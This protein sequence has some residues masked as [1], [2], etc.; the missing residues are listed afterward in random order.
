MDIVVIRGREITILELMEALKRKRVREYIK[1]I[2]F[3]VNGKIVIRLKRELIS[4]LDSLPSLAY[5]LLSIEK[6]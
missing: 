1:G 5:D 3:K 6:Y 4:G 2:G